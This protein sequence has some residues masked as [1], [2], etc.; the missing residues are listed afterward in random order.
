LGTTLKLNFSKLGKKLR[1][2][3]FKIRQAKVCKDNILVIDYQ[4][5]PGDSLYGFSLTWLTNGCV[6]FHALR[7][8]CP[9]IPFSWFI[10]TRLSY[11]GGKMASILGSQRDQAKSNPYYL[12]S[13]HGI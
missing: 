10:H 6:I 13:S 8:D 12:G 3:S 4:V 1:G 7:Q 9:L 5:I 2:Y 11:C